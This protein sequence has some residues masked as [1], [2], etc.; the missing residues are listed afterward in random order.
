[1]AWHTAALLGDV[2]W[3]AEPDRLAAALGQLR[4]YRWDEGQVEEGWI[5]RLAVEDPDNG[6]AAAIGATDLLEEGDEE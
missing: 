3:P 6:W 4:W 5:L 2:P 1:M